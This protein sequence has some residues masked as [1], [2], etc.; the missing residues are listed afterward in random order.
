[1]DR[2]AFLA[3]LGAAGFVACSQPQRH[4]LDDTDVDAIELGPRPDD[5]T[6]S[7]VSLVPEDTAVDVTT[8]TGPYPFEVPQEHLA[9]ISFVARALGA[10]TPVFAELG[11]V[12][13]GWTFANPIASGGPLVFLVDEVTDVG[14]HRVLLP[15]RPNGS[16]GWVRD[17]DI[18]LEFH[19]Y[20]ILVELGE[21]RFTLFDHD[22]IAFTAQVG[23]ARDNAPTP[24]GIYYT[25]ELLR[26]PTPDTAYGVYAY[27][28]SG[29]SETFVEFAGGPG[30]LGIHGTNDPSSLGSQV[31]S[32]CVRMANDDIS[33]LV[34]QVGLPVGVPVEVR[35]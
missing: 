35:A 14:R 22:E 23:V 4:L 34:E 16:F 15:V 24:D 19:N 10:E 33:Y 20:A 1:M 26:P 5:P 3:A 28:L 29:Y 8:T 25:T 31:S 12:E 32:G 13:P 7:D 27:G 11:D 2:R 17:A 30:Q 6:A 21:F 9:G 18:R